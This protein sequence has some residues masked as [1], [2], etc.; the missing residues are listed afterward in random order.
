[1]KYR[2]LS[3][4]NQ[5][6]FDS[7]FADNLQYIEAVSG[8]WPY[9]VQTYD[10]KKSFVYDLCETLINSHPTASCIISTDN[11]KDVAALF[12]LMNASEHV[13][14][15]G[16]L[17]GD[18]NGSRS[19]IYSPEW[20]STIIEF[21]KSIGAESGIFQFFENSPALIPS[22]DAYNITEDKLTHIDLGI[23]KFVSMKIW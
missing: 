20:L 5:I 12:G 2:I 6:N 4:L 11:G 23:F 7:M 17:T 18:E 15:I 13:S 1:M 19:Y 21:Q 22:I 9:D 16:L 10:Q 14:S 3:E 8:V